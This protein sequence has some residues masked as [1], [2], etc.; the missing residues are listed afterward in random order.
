MYIPLYHY[1]EHI[2]LSKVTKLLAT[3]WGHAHTTLFN[4]LIFKKFYL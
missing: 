2:L 1:Y 4:I 3:I